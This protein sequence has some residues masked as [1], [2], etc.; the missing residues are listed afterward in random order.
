MT[1]QQV[2]GRFYDVNLDCLGALDGW[3]PLGTDGEYEYT[4]VDLTRVGIPY[5]ACDNGP[6]TADSD[7][8]FGITVWGL[9]E[10][11]SYAYPA[12]GNIGVINNVV[13]IS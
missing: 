13:V 9:D 11:A 7:A 2:N 5:G 12:G 4:N 3:Q 1:R 6:H 10:W 8:P